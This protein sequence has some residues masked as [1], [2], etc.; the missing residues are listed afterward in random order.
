MLNFQ[1]LYET[2]ATEVYRFALWLSGDRSE[3][4]DIA[5]ETMVRAWVRFDTIRTETLKGYLLTIARNLY[6]EGQRKVKRQVALERHIKHD[7]R[8]DVHQDH[9]DQRRDH[10]GN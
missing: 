2:Y 1:D 4:E 10:I 9:V 6:L 8:D 5:S 3:A 7:P